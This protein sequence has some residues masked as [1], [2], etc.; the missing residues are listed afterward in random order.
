MRDFYRKLV[1]CNFKQLKDSIT[2][3]TADDRGQLPV[4][5]D[6]K[7][8]I[9]RFQPRWQFI[10]IVAIALVLGPTTMCSETS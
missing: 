3:E 7:K 2:G 6:G 9:K 1:N 8:L 5:N 4:V 10:R